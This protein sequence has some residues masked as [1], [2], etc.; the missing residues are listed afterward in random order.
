MV[1]LYRISNYAYGRCGDIMEFKKLLL[2]LGIA[3]TATVG[4]MFGVT[5]GWYEYSSARAAVKASTIKEIP[6]VIFTSDENLHISRI[7][8]IYDEDRYTYAEKNT[9]TV[10]IGENLKNY[11]TGIE[12]S[13]TNLK[14]DDDLKIKDYK[15]ELLQ[16]GV[17][18]S[19][20]DFSGVGMSTNMSI[21]P[22]TKLIPTSFPQ[23]YTYDIYI[24]LSENDTNQNNLMNKVFNAKLNVNNAIKK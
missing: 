20:G 9:F 13:L 2:V 8:P 11:E 1:Y 3:M 18:V 21:M 15:Y 5:Y 19:S 10:T 24:W 6:T 16:D 17:P 23:T 7:M 22:M 14:I 4:V 12:I